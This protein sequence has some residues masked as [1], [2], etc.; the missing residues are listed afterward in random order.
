MSNVWCLWYV[1]CMLTGTS[2]GTVNQNTYNGFSMGPRLPHRM[3]TSGLLDFSNGSSGLQRWTSQL[4]IQSHAAFYALATES[5][6]CHFH[7]FIFVTSK[8][9]AHWYSKREDSTLPGDGDGG[10]P[11]K[12]H[13]GQELLLQ[14]SSE[15]TVCHITPLHLLLHSAPS[16]WCITVLHTLLSSMFLHIPF[17]LTRLSFPACYPHHHLTDWSYNVSLSVDAWSTVKHG[18]S[19][20]SKR[21]KPHCLTVKRDR[22]YWSIMKVIWFLK[23]CTIWSRVLVMKK[24]KAVYIRDFEFHWRYTVF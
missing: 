10:Q 15:S 2:S 14:L 18:L 3:A 24:S 4:I 13:V 16:I 19:I 23:A 21:S 12:G 9:Q 6:Q 22:D 7:R 11:L 8:S 17:P 5:T 1:T 20:D